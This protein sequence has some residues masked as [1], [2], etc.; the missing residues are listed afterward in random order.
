MDTKLRDKELTELMN[1]RQRW[2]E[3]GFSENNARALKDK[4]ESLSSIR[5]GSYNFFLSCIIEELE[6]KGGRHAETLETDRYALP[7]RNQAND[8]PNYVTCFK[9][10]DGLIHGGIIKTPTFTLT[11]RAF[12]LV[13]MY[14][15]SGSSR[16]KRDEIREVAVC[17]VCE[18]KDLSGQIV[19]R[20]STADF[21]PL[22]T[23]INRGNYSSTSAGVPSPAIR[24]DNFNKGKHHRWS[25]SWF[26]YYFPNGFNVFGGNIYD[27]GSPIYEHWASLEGEYI[28]DRYP[29]GANGVES[30][31]FNYTGQW[32]KE[33]VISTSYLKVFHFSPDDSEV[34]VAMVGAYRFQGQRKTIIV[35]PYTRMGEWYVKTFT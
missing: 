4:I 34:I 13:Y 17:G 11:C 27:N 30:P 24:L 15:Y 22:T 5:T 32:T 12:R 2:I 14:R 29:A 8:I 33:F 20:W 3:D 35:N 23:N 28:W 10:H 31:L 7:P 26:G 16:E 9:E 6:G 19:E 21:L 25:G 1:L 18:K